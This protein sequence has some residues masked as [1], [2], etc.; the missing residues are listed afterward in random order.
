MR[1]LTAAIVLVLVLLAPACDT[2]G[3]LAVERRDGGD[4]SDCMRA[5]GAGGEAGGGGAAG[6]E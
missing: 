3:L 1:T 5:G 2:G 6:C 4:G